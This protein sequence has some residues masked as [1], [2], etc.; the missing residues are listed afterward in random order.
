MSIEAHDFHTNRAGSSRFDFVL[1]SEQIHT[2]FA[3][4][5]VQVSFH[6]NP[7][8]GRFASVDIAH[9]RYSRL[10]D[11]LWSARMLPYE[12]FPRAGLV[13]FVLGLGFLGTAHV[14]SE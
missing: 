1:V 9:N 14:V 4:A 13:F 12:K 10:N 11:L 5:I 3:S 2:S 7:K 8:H 6:Q